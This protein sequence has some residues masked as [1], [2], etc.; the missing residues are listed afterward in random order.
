MKSVMVTIQKGGQGKTMLSVHLAV[1]AASK[2]LK[3]LFL[4]LDMQGNS[5]WTL[6]KHATGITSS[7]FCHNAFDQIPIP[8]DNI[9]LVTGDDGMADA[10]DWDKVAVLKDYAE[11]LNRCSEHFDLCVIDTP[12]TLGFAQS[13]TGMLVDYVTAPVTMDWYSIQGLLKLRTIISNLIAKNPKLTML[14]VIPNCFDGRKPRLKENYKH[15]KEMLGDEILPFIIPMR[16]SISE[17]LADPDMRS[18]WSSQKTASRPAK[19]ILS[20]LCDFLLQRMGFHVT[21]KDN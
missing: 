15:I 2:G 8:V 12:P 20:N 5:S 19:K 21:N 16:D 13:V 14:G 1:Y 6:Q 10:D 17:A 9:A 7:A 11:A 3:V 4:D 18:V